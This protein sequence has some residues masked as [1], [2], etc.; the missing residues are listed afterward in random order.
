MEDVETNKLLRTAKLIYIFFLAAILIY[1]D[2][3]RR[4][5]LIV[6]SALF[7]EST[8]RLATVVLAVLGVSALASTY[9]LP[10]LMI[11]GFKKKPNLKRKTGFWLS[12]MVVRAAMFEA[13]VI[14]GLILGILGANLRIIWP[15]FVMPAVGLLITFPTKSRMEKVLA[16][17]AEA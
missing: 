5:N 11:K 14:Y 1:I 2:I 15:F 13:I 3:L 7:E 10:Q 9:F 17:I 6:H 12:L 8:V 4:W 16:E